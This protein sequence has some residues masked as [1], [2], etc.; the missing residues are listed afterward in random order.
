MKV[1]S[2]VRENFCSSKASEK[3]VSETPSLSQFIYFMFCPSLL[4]RNSYPLSQT[5]SWK[6]VFN[7]LIHCFASIYA[8]N[9]SFTQ[10]V[11]PLFNKI[12]YGE[13][14]VGWHLL[15]LIFPSAIPGAVCLFIGIFYG[16]LHSWLSMFSEAM[17]FADRHFYSNWWSSRSMAYYYRTWNLVVHEWLYTYI[18]RDI[19]KM[20]GSSRFANALAQISVFF[21]SAVFHEYWFTVSLRMFFPIIF[22]LY[23]G[24]GG[25]LFLIS[26]L[27]KKPSSLWNIF[28]WWNLM[29]GTGL[30]FTC[31]ASEWYARQRC[32]RIYEND[33]L[34]LLIPRIW[35]CQHRLK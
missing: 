1:H 27:I 12:S 21:I 33:Y 19:S 15:T 10:I 14:G 6:K 23:F 9:I 5:R 16:L 3:N 31:Y 32:S 4:Y 29:F 25:I 24:F 17:Y 26:T 20:L 18:Y 7:H 11:I 30:F 22:T 13:E 8:I 35:D 34:D 28:L 2:F